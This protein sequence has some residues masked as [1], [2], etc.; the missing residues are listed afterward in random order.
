MQDAGLWAE[1]VDIQ[2]HDKC[3]ATDDVTRPDTASPGTIIIE[4]VQRAASSCLKA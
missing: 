2:C 1:E 3:D 4:E